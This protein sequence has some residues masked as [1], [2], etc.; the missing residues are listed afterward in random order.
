VRP[1]GIGAALA[2]AAGPVVVATARAVHSGWIP[3]GD[4]AYFTI[5]SRD[6]LTEHHPLVGAWS[7]G[8]SVVG[9]D[10]N[11]LGPL[12]LDLLALPVRVLGFGTGTAAGVAL[13]NL[14]A[15][16]MVVVLLHRRPIVGGAWWGALLATLTSWTLG[17]ELLFE[18]RQH[19][20]LV[21]PFLAL[22]VGV[23]ASADGDRWAVPA[24]AFVASLVVQ[25][26]LSF[27]VPVVAVAGS[28]VVLLAA[29]HRWA[30]RWRG[31]LLTTAVVVAI[32]W[33][34]PLVEQLRNDPGNLRAVLDASRVDQASYGAAHAVR[35]LADVLLPP[36]GWWRGSF[37]AF[38]P[39]TGLPGTAWALVGVGATV[40]VVAA[41][42]LGAHRDGR[43]TTSTWLVV[44]LAA[45][46]GSLLA[47]ATSPSAG[48]FGP[49]A[50]N[51]RYLWPVAIFTIVGLAQALAGHLPARTCSGVA[52]VLIGVSLLLAAASVPTSYQSP[53]PETDARLIPVAR[54]LFDQVRRADLDGTVVVDRRGL[55]F[56]EPYT[57]VV[58][59]ALQEAGVGLAFDAPTDQL[60]FGSARRPRGDAFGTVTFRAGSAALDE[61]RGARLLARASALP[62]RDLERLRS[63]ERTAR[64]VPLDDDQAST[65]D[66]LRAQAAATTVAVWLTPTYD[67]D[68]APL[69]RIGASRPVPLALPPSVLPS[70]WYSSSTLTSQMSWVAP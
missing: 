14:A 19:H 52:G 31:P 63:L 68:E 36:S 61:V 45:L 2:V 22:L 11:N 6:V 62:E 33:A 53:G 27:L 43:R 5:R 44:A 18:P 15:I 30:P 49:V 35:A 65:L 4:N 26:H 40:A 38:D 28:G 41:L 47:A 39:A 1:T 56:G 60:R 8:S 25:T 10:V 32:A 12:Q 24:T 59:G 20:A 70:S 13:T 37:R 69:G 9:V 64:S 50:G 21:L 55:Y 42:A 66:S 57:Y 34:Q 16:A 58:V 7:S 67:G 29:R 54:D 17:S 51:F 23:V 3:M 46:G 48:P